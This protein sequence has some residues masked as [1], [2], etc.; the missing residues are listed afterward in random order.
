MSYTH[1][2]IYI[3]IYIYLYTDTHIYI[4]IHTHTYV[5]IEEPAGPH[6][7]MLPRRQT[8]TDVMSLSAIGVSYSISGTRYTAHT[9]S[10]T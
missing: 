3:Y 1:M 2:C 9:H 8:S 7:C 5:Y 10:L 6:I 4:Y